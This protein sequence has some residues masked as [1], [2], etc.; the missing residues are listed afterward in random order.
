MTITGEVVEIWTA[1][2][3]ASY[4]CEAW[5]GAVE[6]IIETGRRLT[7]AKQRIGHGKWLDAVAL[8]PF[9]EDS[10]QLLM[11]ISKHPTLSNTEYIRY[12]P[13]SWGTL[14]VLAQLPADEVSA[15]IDSG[16]ITPE[17]Q[18][19][20][21]KTLVSAS[22]G[23]IEPGAHVGNNSGDNEWY[24]PEEYIAAAVRVMGG[25]DLDPAS[26]PTANDNVGAATF[27]TAQ[28]NGLIQPWNGRL[29]MNPPYA[30]PL[31][32]QFA[33]RMAEQYRAGNVKAAIV[34]VN[35]GTET[36][37]FQTLAAVASAVCFPKGRIKFW[38][39]DKVAVPLQGQAFLYIGDEPEVFDAEF[40][41]FGFT[42]AI[43]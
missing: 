16:E 29:W 31:I 4:V 36:Q 12:L 41:Q 6:S 11:K 2:E 1:Q 19:S 23:A 18:Q 13:P 40:A 26:S 14:A 25:I 35:N 43:I 3:A 37:W 39:P 10:A 27:Y 8:M 33:E 17:L 7:T 9:G 32:G 15:L 34:L 30:Q 20:E 38:H 21:A 28:D 5:Q 24:T 22:R 42:M